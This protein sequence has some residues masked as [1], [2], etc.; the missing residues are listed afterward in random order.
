[1]LLLVIAVVEHYVPWKTELPWALSMASVSLTSPCWPPIV[2]LFPSFWASLA[3]GCLRRSHPD[4]SSF[5]GKVHGHV[6]TSGCVP[7]I[8]RCPT[9]LFWLKSTTRMR[10]S[11]RQSTTTGRFSL[12]SAFSLAPS[13]VISWPT[14]STEVAIAPI[15]VWHSISPLLQ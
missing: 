4:S 1:M 9:S 14:L 6:C 5:H 8:D 15:L 2:R 12:W 3:H 13:S 11:A 10:P 7:C